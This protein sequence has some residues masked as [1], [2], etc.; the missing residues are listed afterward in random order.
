[1]PTQNKGAAT[2]NA[3]NPQ[4]PQGS[5][6]QGGPQGSGPQGPGGPQGPP[7]RYEGALIT[8]PLVLER[9]KKKKKKKYSRG[10]KGLQRLTLGV[11]DALFRTAN[12]VARG[13]R[14]FSKRS[15]KSARRR[16]DGLVRDSLRNASRGFANGLTE[17]G[18]APSEIARR[19]GTGQVRRGF[20][21]IVPFVPFGN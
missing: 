1:M 7:G 17:L 4:G 21:V 11:S 6:P 16:R 13:T 20:R 5:G 14:T 12:S 3:P 9:W 2:V 18:E 19:I 8:T 10:T 15:N